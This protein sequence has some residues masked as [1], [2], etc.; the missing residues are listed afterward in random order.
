MYS[1]GEE[2]IAI[3]Q[4]AE[5]KPSINTICKLLFLFTKST[6][7]G[8]Y[9]NAMKTTFIFKFW[10]L[11]SLIRIESLQ[12][13]KE[14]LFK[15]TTSICFHVH[16]SPLFEILLVIAELE[17][18]VVLTVLIYMTTIICVQLTCMDGK[19]NSGFKS[20]PNQ[21]LNLN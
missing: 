15:L 4:T 3:K 16:V 11:T 17:K 8:D 14:K 7:V 5:F 2:G 19:W 18:K 10:L 21:I 20:W 9:I 13:T 12:V 6:V 1:D